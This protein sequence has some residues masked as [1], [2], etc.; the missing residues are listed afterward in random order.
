M[1]WASSSGWSWYAVCEPGV[2]RPRHRVTDHDEAGRCD[3]RQ[4]RLIR[5]MILER[6]SLDSKERREAGQHPRA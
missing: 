1:A 5:Q 3:G 4:R 6:P 2:P